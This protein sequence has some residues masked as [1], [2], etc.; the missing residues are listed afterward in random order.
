MDKIFVGYVCHF[1]N[2]ESIN[3]FNIIKNALPENYCLYFIS[4]TYLENTSCIE[5]FININIPKD[6]FFWQNNTKNE[7]IYTYIYNLYNEYSYYWFIEYDVIFN[8]NNT[9]ENWKDLFSAFENKDY[10]LMCYHFNKYV[11]YYKQIYD[12]ERILQSM[13][14]DD[15]I[16]TK[17]N[18][19]P[20]KLLTE[21]LHFGFFPLCRM[22]NKLMNIVNN[23]YKLYPHNN[24]FEYI[25]PTLAVYNNC[26]IYNFNTNTNYY[27]FIDVP[28]KKHCMFINNGSM[29]WYQEDKTQY[30]ENMIIHPVKC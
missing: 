18:D 27:Q 21:N 29:G 5:N 17:T 30:N 28:S 12:T 16:K 3:R 11:N 24:F 9:S 23:Y 6:N 14:H 8:K 1:Q 25:I 7:L 19:N 10:D 26:S 20:N 15:I 2:E 4:A 22:S 13:Y